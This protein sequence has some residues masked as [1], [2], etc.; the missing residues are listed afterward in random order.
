MPTLIIPLISQ[1]IDKFFPSKEAADAAKLEVLRMSQ[2]GELAQLAAETALAT[3]QIEVNKIEAASSNLFVAGWRPMCGW[4][5]AMSLGFKY[6]GGPAVVMIS[7]ILGHQIALPEINATELMPLLIGML[8]L[9]AMRTT[10]K[11][12]GVS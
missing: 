7:G 8:G 12:K 11:I 9:G 2:Q 3:G 1:L 5:C 4:I 6:I 10:E